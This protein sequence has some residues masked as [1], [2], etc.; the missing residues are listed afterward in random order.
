MYGFYA[1]VQSQTDKFLGQSN[2][3]EQ[4]NQTHEQVLQRPSH[5]HR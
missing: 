2:S 4:L 5:L 3:A 1:C